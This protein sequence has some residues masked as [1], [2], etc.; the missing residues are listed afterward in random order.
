MSGFLKAIVKLMW[1]LQ[2][3]TVCF[4]TMCSNPAFPWIVTA[5][6]QFLQGGTLLVINGVITPINGLIN[7]SGG[8]T[9]IFFLLDLYF[10]GLVVLVK[11][12]GIKG[13]ICSHQPG[14]DVVEYQCS[15]PQPWEN[16]LKAASQEAI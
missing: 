2:S 4:K 10:G 15:Y 9:P 8:I 13:G 6:W 3:V 11:V 5:F 12:D 16:D 14:V 7:E 1:G